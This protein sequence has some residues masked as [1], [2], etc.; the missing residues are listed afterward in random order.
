MT[1]LR[2]PA[3]ALAVLALAL[4]LAA[5]GEKSEEVSGERQGFS[6]TLDFYPNPDH[7]GI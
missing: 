6:L 4:L 1:R 3:I 5:C 7:A 2:I